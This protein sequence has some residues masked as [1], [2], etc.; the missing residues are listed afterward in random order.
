MGAPGPGGRIVVITFHSIEDR[1]VKKRFVEFAKNNGKLLV[2]KPLI[3]ARAEITHNPSARSA[4]MRAIEKT[5]RITLC[6]HSLSPTLPISSAPWPFLQLLLRSRSFSTGYFCLKQWATPQSAPAL[7]RQVRNTHLQ[8]QRLEQAYLSA[9]RE[10]TLERAQSDGLYNPEQVTTV[11]APLRALARSR[12]R[13]LISMTNARFISRVR[14]V[15]ILCAL[16]ALV[17]VGRLYVLQVLHSDMYIARAD[18]QFSRQRAAPRPQ[19]YIF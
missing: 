5:N 18:A 11:F 6:T 13:A 7:E 3:A 2:K 4:K 19:Q 12:W 8:G 16:C 14:W 1:L 17:I 15:T 9:T 10:M